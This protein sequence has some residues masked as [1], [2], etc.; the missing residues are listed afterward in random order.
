MLCQKLRIRLVKL[1]DNLQLP[2]NEFHNAIQIFQ[3]HVN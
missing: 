1:G 3:Q 2:F